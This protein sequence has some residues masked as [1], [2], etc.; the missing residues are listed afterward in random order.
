LDIYSEVKR[1]NIIILMLRCRMLYEVR[2][3]V[4][5]LLILLIQKDVTII[6]YNSLGIFIGD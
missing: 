1:E 4:K 3:A 5:R 2:A 6:I